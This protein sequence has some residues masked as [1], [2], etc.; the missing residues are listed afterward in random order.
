[1]RD[2]EI[3]E[4]SMALRDVASKRATD[5]RP[6]LIPLS[7]PVTGKNCPEIAGS[8]LSALK[9]FFDVRLNDTFM[10]LAFDVD[11]VRRQLAQPPTLDDDEDPRNADLEHLPLIVTNPNPFRVLLKDIFVNG[12]ATGRVYNKDIDCGSPAAVTVSI[13]SLGSRTK[14]QLQGIFDVITL[15][16]REY[17]LERVV[18]TDGG[19]AVF[20]HPFQEGTVIL[21]LE[22]NQNLS[23]DRELVVT[24]GKTSTQKFTLK[25]GARTWRIILPVRL[26]GDDISAFTSD[27]IPVKFSLET[28]GSVGNPPKAEP[29][30]VLVDKTTKR[31]WSDIATIIAGYMLAVMGILA[32]LITI[33]QA[34]IVKWN[35]LAILAVLICALGT[36]YTQFVM[37]EGIGKHEILWISLV[38]AAM[39]LVIAAATWLILVFGIWPW[40]WERK[41]LLSPA[42]ANRYRN[43]TRYTLVAVT[44]VTFIF[45]FEVIR[46]PHSA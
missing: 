12:K 35:L 2:A 4:M 43:I 1:V 29:P 24:V 13:P 9:E 28:P 31:D 37:P 25:R 22:I 42:N 8:V 32:N 23:A 26:K 38:S 11:E 33:V 3:K 34:R 14:V 15:P 5:I 45:S 19:G 41:A 27:K 16:P 40:V 17:V 10:N 6:I 46:L 7:P 21:Q 36:Y 44:V 20:P 30:G 18:L 39:A